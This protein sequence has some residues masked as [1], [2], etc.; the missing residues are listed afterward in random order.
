MSA[1]D[2]AKR[3]LRERWRALLWIETFLLSLSVLIGML[4]L[5]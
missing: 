5:D 2:T 3:R 4:W 1:V